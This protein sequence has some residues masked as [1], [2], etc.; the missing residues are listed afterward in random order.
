M[1]DETEKTEETQSQTDS[2]AVGSENESKGTEV[3]TEDW[4]AKYKESQAATQKAVEERDEARNTLDTVYPAV[5]FA[6]LQGAGEEEEGEKP[7]LTQEDLDRHTQAI[8]NKLLTIDFRQKH[9]ELREYEASL[10]GPTIARIR[11]QN[12]RMPVSEVLEKAATETTTFLE[13]ERNKGKTEAETKKA[14]AAAAAGLGSASSTSSKKKE[15]EGESRKDY[16]ARRRKQNLQG[17]NLA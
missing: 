2:E 6:K 17:R 3:K 8:D 9:P 1:A 11:R 5:D 14:E 15:D 10:V 16:F 4:E 7:A 13:T 12:P